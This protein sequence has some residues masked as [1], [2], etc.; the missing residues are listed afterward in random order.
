M[1]TPLRH[2]PA[3]SATATTTT[4]YVGGILHRV[5]PPNDWQPYAETVP[6]IRSLPTSA[7]N[8]FIVS[9][10]S[11]SNTPYDHRYQVASNCPRWN[12]KI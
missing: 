12:E 9:N 8:Y 11:P 4:N 1:A 3:T 6:S 10:G 2:P 5:D 7:Y